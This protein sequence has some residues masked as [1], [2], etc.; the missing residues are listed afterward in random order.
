MTPH[1]PIILLHNPNQDKTDKRV[2]FSIDQ[3]MVVLSTLISLVQNGHLPRGSITSVARQYKCHRH[4]IKTIWTRYLKGV[5]IGNRRSESTKVVKQRMIKKINRD[6][7]KITHEK[8]TTIRSL[9]QQLG[10]SRGTTFNLIKQGMI[11][12]KTIHLKPALTDKQKKERLNFC[13]QQIDLPNQCFSSF[14]NLIHIDEKWFFMKKDHL[15]I[16]SLPD[17]P[18]LNRKAT[19]KRYIDKVM[20]LISMCL[21]RYDHKRNKQFNG[22]LG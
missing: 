13:L 20:F 21:P 9:S 5:D 10:V 18:E 1:S 2:N 14:H 19:N 8:R 3:R 16:Y 4:T 12:K 22:K 6:L 15:S 17:D 11:K 7:P